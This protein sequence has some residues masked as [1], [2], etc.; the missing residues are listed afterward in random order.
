MTVNQY[1]L[2][3]AGK[4]RPKGWAK[5][6]FGGDS[7]CFLGLAPQNRARIL[8][9]T[10]L[11]MKPYT[12]FAGLCALLL[13]FVTLSA[14]E[15]PIKVACIGDSITQGVGADRG[16][17]YPDQLQTLLGEK[18]KVGNFGVSA[19]TLL[20]KGDFPY[21]KEKK[22]Q[23]ALKMLPNIVIIMLGTNDTKPQNWKYEAEFVGD[24]RDLIKSFQ[25]LPSKPK[26]YV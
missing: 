1:C 23:E 10:P 21:R 4:G 6:A 17:S 20:Q 25:A 24:Y 7:Q 11:P 22:Y 5:V 8:P 16:Q 13:S 15:E 9:F 19:R 26:V 14:A 2:R 12:R 3:S 18:Y